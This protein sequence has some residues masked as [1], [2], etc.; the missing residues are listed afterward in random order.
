[1]SLL[2]DGRTIE[3]EWNPGLTYVVQVREV[4]DD[5]W[6]FVV[7]TQLRSITVP[8]LKPDTE[9]GMEVREK[10][11]TGEREPAISRIWTSPN[12]K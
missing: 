12:G 7:H 3:A 10:N 5:N 2:P 1:M 11:E 8:D 9:S 6:L 4:G